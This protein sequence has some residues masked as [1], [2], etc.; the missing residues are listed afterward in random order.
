MVTSSLYLQPNQQLQGH[1]LY[2]INYM[3]KNY[4]RFRVNNEN[5]FTRIFLNWNYFDLKKTGSTIYKS[6]LLII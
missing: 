6:K 1:P 2:V 5:I 4:F 3:Y